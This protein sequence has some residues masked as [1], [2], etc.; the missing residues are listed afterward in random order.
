MKDGVC[1]PDD[2]PVSLNKDA[3]AISKKLPPASAI[4]LSA[5]E[6]ILDVDAL[7]EVYD[8]ADAASKS[9]RQNRVEAL[10]RYIDSVEGSEPVKHC[11]YKVAHNVLALAIKLHRG[12]DL[13]SGHML[14]AMISR[15][16]RFV[17]EVIRELLIAFPDKIGGKSVTYADAASCASIEELRGRFIDEELDAKGRESH[18]KQLEYLSSL[19]EMKLG[20]DEPTLM[21]DFVEVTE[22]R[23]CHVHFGGKVSPQYR[24][25]CGAEGVQFKTP[26]RDGEPLPVTSE[27]FR[28][29]RCILSEVAF[30]LSQS[31]ARKVF[32]DMAFI[33]EV[34]IDALGLQMLN[35]HRWKE[36]LM[37]FDYAAKLRGAWVWNESLRRNYIIHKAQA[38]KG[39]G[40]QDAAVRSIESEDWSAAHS[41]YLLAIAL[42]KDNFDGAAELMSAAGF[43][44][45]SYHTWPIFE[46]F[47]ETTQ[48]KTEFNKLFGKDFDQSES[49]AL[50][51]AV[52]AAVAEPEAFNSVGATAETLLERGEEWGRTMSDSNSTEAVPDG[53]ES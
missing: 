49:K 46:A 27:Y 47:R 41:R 23:N 32:P 30:K 15:F 25:V 53:S 42:I 51:K 39:L 3:N 37:V 45:N 11:D 19:T 50:T 9:G 48:F 28:N 31:I 22:R 12:H 14:V 33:A 29:A 1:S 5:E 18:L 17:T 43:S 6:F 21:A 35:E 52:E 2:G 40:K 34:H 10:S 24:R 36:A 16:D 7:Q 38:L 26:P 44:E 8:D 13:L 20:T 4:L